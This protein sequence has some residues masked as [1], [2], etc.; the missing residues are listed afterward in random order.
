MIYGN[1]SYDAVR[2]IENSILLRELLDTGIL[3]PLLDMPYPDDMTTIN[4]L[5][6]LVAVAQ[7][8]D[9]ERM[10]YI[11]RVEVDLYGVM[12][13][14]LATYGVT[15]SSEEIKNKLDVYDPIEDYLKIYY[16]RPRPFQTAAQFGIP[17]YPLLKTDASSASYPGGHTLTSLWFRDIYMKEHPELSGA[18]MRFVIDIKRTREEGGVHYP[19]D[20]LFS[21]RIYK[22]LK[23]YI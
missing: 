14:Y 8:V 17:L 11:N 16:N 1:P 9:S 23:N 15:V 6:Y 21:M 10:D 7:S 18:L 22:H 3:A 19:S 20:S 5:R 4:E 13:E 2:G 12:S